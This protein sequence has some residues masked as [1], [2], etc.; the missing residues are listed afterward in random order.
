[1]QLLCN[2]IVLNLKICRTIECRYLIRTP[3]N[4]HRSTLIKIY[5]AFTLC[6]NGSCDNILRAGK[7]PALLQLKS[8]YDKP[9]SDTKGGDGNDYYVQNVDSRCTIMLISCIF[10]ISL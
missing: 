7:L 8:W 6:K 10:H 1:M 3:F 5:K 2:P 4:T 9:R